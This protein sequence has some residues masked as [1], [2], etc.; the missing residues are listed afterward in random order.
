MAHVVVDRFFI[1]YHQFLIAEISF[2]VEVVDVIFYKDIR[3]IREREREE[4]KEERGYI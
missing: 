4:K 1:I 2:V 3:R